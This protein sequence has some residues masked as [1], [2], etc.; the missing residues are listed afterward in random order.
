MNIN[1]SIVNY[2]ILNICACLQILKPVFVFEV[3]QLAYPFHKL[4]IKEIVC[5]H[6]C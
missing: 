4:E 5:L 2:P 3:Q 6:N 1:I